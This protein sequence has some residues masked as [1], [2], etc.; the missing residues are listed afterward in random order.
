[1]AAHPQD[2]PRSSLAL[3]SDLRLL[4]VG[5]L[6]VGDIFFPDGAP[7]GRV[8]LRRE[9]AQRHRTEDAGMSVRDLCRRRGIS[10]GTYGRGSGCGKRQS[11]NC[12][13]RPT[14]ERHIC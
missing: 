12:H 9:I 8:R 10:H 3:A 5:G 6:D 4:E 1:M 13:V 11:A 14:R 2:D 7:R